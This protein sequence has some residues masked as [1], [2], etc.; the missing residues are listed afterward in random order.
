LGIEIDSDHFEEADFARFRERLRAGLTT[1]QSV[2]ARPGFGEGERTLGAELE[3]FLIGDRAQPL[4]VS[5]Q[6]VRDAGDPQVTPEMGVY[7]IELST[8]PVVLADRPFAQLGAQMREAIA[9]IGAQAAKY[10]ARAVPISVLPTLDREHFGAGSITDLPRYRALAAGLRRLRDAPFHICIDGADPLELTM[11]GPAMEGANTAFQVHLRVTP[12]EF[13][14]LFNAAMMLTGPV[15]AAAA[16]S[17]TFLGHRL[18]HETRIALFKQAGDDRP[19]DSAGTTMQPA[20]ISFG[21]GWVRDGAAELFQESVA[22][23]EPILPVCGDAEPGDERTGDGSAPALTEL[24]LHHGTVWKWNRPVYDPTGS[25]HLRIELRALPSG[26]TV[27]D[28]LANAAFLV[29]AILDLGSGSDLAHLLPA[30]PFAL[31]DRNFY[32]AAQMGLD[33]ELGWPREPGEAPAPVRARDLLLSL[34]PRAA[35]GLT[36]A[37]VA[38]DEIRHYL[39]IFERRVQSGQ[40]GA[41]WQ[42]RTLEALRARG[43]TLD[44]A[45]RRMVEMYLHHSDGGQPVHTWPV[46]D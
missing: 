31:A 18:W 9:V 4:P 37:G 24:R 42:L 3:L 12:A 6:V 7:T 27:D 38:R 32:R 39:G 43:V 36:A 11:S 8:P 15:L 16:N 28:M 26:P 14:P 10:G 20:R 45:R 46:E 5:P 29:G 2:L 23:Y 33:A 30:F 35:V 13:A 21:N 17:P 19:P 25:G 22:L 34:L 40:T 41:V 44:D 1:L